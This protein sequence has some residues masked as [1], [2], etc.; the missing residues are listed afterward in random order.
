MILNTHNK[1]SNFWRR[2]E[3]PKVLNCNS[4]MDP[5]AAGSV[6]LVDDEEALP[7]VASGDEDLR[8]SRKAHT[9]CIWPSPL[10]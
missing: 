9:A 6:E 2:G 3:P 1:A 8:R 10:Q 4:F 5:D 7:L